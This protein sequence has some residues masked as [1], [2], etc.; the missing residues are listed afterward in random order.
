MDVIEE[1]IRRKAEVKTDNWRR[2]H[3][4]IKDLL[5]QK[6]DFSRVYEEKFVHH[7]EKK[8]LYL[9]IYCIAN[10]DKYSKLKVELD[11]DVKTKD[12][13][14]EVSFTTI[15][16]LMTTYPENT[17][18]KKSLFYFAMRAIW[19]KIYYGWARAKYR[20]FAIETANNV[21]NRITEFLATVK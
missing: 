20:N 4:Q 21:T 10:L 19:D 7:E 13:E 8:T 5:E 15:A 17:P 6:F 11:I 1:V 14:G 12:E 2:A 18:F 16:T 9:E 3:T